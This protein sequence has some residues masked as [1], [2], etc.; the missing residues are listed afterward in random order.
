MNALKTG[1][2]T[3]V[4]TASMLV[5]ALIFHFKT[6]MDTVCVFGAPGIGKTEIVKQVAA[7]LGFNIVIMHPQIADPTDFKGMPAVIVD[8]ET[9]KRVAVFLPFAELKALVEA[10]SPTV[11]F[12]DDFGQAPRAV[13]AAIQQLILERRVDG[14]KIS[15]N[16]RFCLA[17]N[18][19]EDVDQGFLTTIKTYTLEPTIDDYCK[20]AIEM[21][22]RK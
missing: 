15:D 5:K 8:D 9:G 20:W 12:L 1:F 10:D 22:D 19:A 7:L 2:G 16:V 4:L 3:A 13:Q 11:A 14:R 17:A 6:R 18:R 21:E